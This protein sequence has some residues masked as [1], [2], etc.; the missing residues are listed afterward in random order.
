LATPGKELLGEHYDKDHLTYEELEGLALE[1]VTEDGESVPDEELRG[2]VFR[3]EDR[4]EPSGYLVRSTE[5]T[6][7]STT[8]CYLQ[9]S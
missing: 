9:S 6:G 1:V 3:F 7:Q 5:T 8:L 2:K 4:D